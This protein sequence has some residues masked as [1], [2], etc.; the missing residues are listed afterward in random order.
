TVRATNAPT[1]AYAEGTLTLNSPPPDCSEVTPPDCDRG[2][3]FG[4]NF[5]IP[6]ACMQISETACGCVSGTCGTTAPNCSE[7]CLAPDVCVDTGPVLLG[8]FCFCVGP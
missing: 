8:H 2:Q 5:E 6:H 7:S 1:G 3:C 4:R